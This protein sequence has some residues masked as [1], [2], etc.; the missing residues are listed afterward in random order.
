MA[1][2][3][4]LAVVAVAVVIVVIA[5]AA[6]HLRSRLRCAGFAGPGVTAGELPP[7]CPAGWLRL[8]TWNVRNFPLDERAG[9][10]EL[11]FARQ[12]NICDLEDALAGLDADVLGLAEIRDARRFPPILRRTA[13]DRAYKVVMSRHGGRWSQRVAIAWDDRVLEAVGGPVEIRE[14]VVD[15][16]LRPAL[17]LR[18]RG[19]GRPGLDFTVVQV[20]LKASPKGYPVRIEQHRA[21]I[22]WL[23]RWSGSASGQGLVV[24]GDFNTTG[25]ERGSTRRELET[26]DR[27]YGRVG[28]SRVPNAAGCTEYWEGEGEADGVQLPSQ[29]DH[30]L[31]RGLGGDLPAARPWLHC[32][33]AGCGP[34]VSRPGEEDGTFWDVSDHCP[35]TVDLPW[36]AGS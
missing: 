22:E 6:L 10:P 23:R 30:I 5:A 21:L 26:V 14:V 25:G 19:R 36:P 35:L 12:T 11:G 28:L 24:M 17:A 1:R 33:R 16:D 3:S 13:G 20:H 4:K 34:L 8:A 18:L 32:A 27:L 9:D 2:R 29:L 15:E 31:V 7:P